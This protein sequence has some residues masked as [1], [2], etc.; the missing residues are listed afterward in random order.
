MSTTRERKQ[1]NAFTLPEVLVVIA[2]ISLL[3]ALL[4]PAVQSSREIARRATCLN[5]LRQL[6]VAAHNHHQLMGRFPVGLVAIRLNV[7]QASPYGLVGQH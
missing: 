7:A 3:V 1:R 4:L 2:V 6:A 5:N